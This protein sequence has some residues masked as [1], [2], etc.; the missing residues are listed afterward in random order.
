[1]TEMIERAVMAW[2]RSEGQD[3]TVRQSMR[4]ALLAALDVEDE[5]LV[6]RVARAM[7]AD[8]GLH[9]DD[10]EASDVGAK[11]YVWHR[12]MSTARAAIA[13]LK[14]AVQGGPEAKP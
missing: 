8:L 2:A 14:N 1:M 12:E 3:E 7:C 9:A 13:A 5:A 6:E 4:A 10:W 11:V